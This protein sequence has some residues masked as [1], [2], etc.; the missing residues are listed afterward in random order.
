MAGSQ[1][2]S[3]ESRIPFLSLDTAEGESKNVLAG[4]TKLLGRVA[5]SYAVMAHQP[6][7]AKTILPL[8]VSLMREGLGTTLSSKLKEMAV[9]KTSLLNGCDY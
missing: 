9:V 1:G 8:T 5:N 3:T 4:V 2:I 6:Y 7:V